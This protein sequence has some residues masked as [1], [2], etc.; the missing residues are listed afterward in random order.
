MRELNILLA[1]DDMDD[2]FLFEEALE[3]LPLVAQL[4]TVHDGEQL[5]QWLNDKQNKLPHILFLDIN[6]PRK[7][8]LVCLSEIKHSKRLQKLPVIIFSTSI[9]KEMINQVCKEAVHYYIKKPA[10]FSE[11]K[12]I[13]QKAI[14]LIVQKHRPIRKKGGFLLKD[15]SN[16][17]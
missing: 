7:T 15:I 13:I 3:A 12:R 1:D 2:C 5:T 4:T 17:H 9:D 10:E 6:M 16:N 14:T 11:L 8:G